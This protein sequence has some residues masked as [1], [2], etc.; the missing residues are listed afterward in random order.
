V[1]FDAAKLEVRGTGT[2]LVEDLAGNP[3]QGGGEFDF[4]GTGTLVYLAGKTFSQNWPIS[5]L[6]RSG[7]TEPLLHT[8]GAY[9]VP[10][11]SPDGRRLA[12]QE[13]SLKGDDIFVYDWQRDAMTRLTFDG[14]SRNPV[15]SPDGRHIAFWSTSAGHGLYWVRSD[16]AGEPRHL[17]E[18]QNSIVPWSFSPD[19]RRLAYFDTNADTGYDLWTL[20]MDLTDPDHPKPGKPEPFLR[21][22]FDELLPEFFPDGRWIAYASNESGRSEIYV[23][24][25]AAGGAGG[26]WQISTSGGWYAFCSNN[27]RE[28]FY[29]AT[30]NR[31]MVVDY[32]VNGDSFVP[33]K[34]RLWSDK[35]IF[36]PRFLN[37]AL[38]PDGKRFAVFPMPEISNA[39]KS[40]V[41][42]T[43]LLNFFDE[44][45]RRIP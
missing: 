29:E 16:G 32:T 34:P 14:Q 30:D 6:D 21:T 25:F 5:W 12:L 23:R 38:H 9:Y 45:R 33:G 37:L 15:W 1:G 36:F 11:F 40:S 28:L 26:K 35:Q 7:K 39:E 17:L 10:R 13:E 20:P 19:G 22:P 42:V 27:G 24:P 41:H 4:S 31:I 18:N 44:V 3:S 43:M 8:P 2:P